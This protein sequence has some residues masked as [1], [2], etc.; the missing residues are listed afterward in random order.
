MIERG[1]I[2]ATGKI[3]AAIIV[4]LVSLASS[5]TGA[6]FKHENKPQNLK[7]LFER[8][9][10]EIYVKKD[11]KQAT[12][13]FRSLIPDEARTMKALKDNAAPD[14]LRQINDMHA[15]LGSS[16]TP[17]GIG[18]VARATQKEVQVHGATTED[19]ARYRDG[20][21]AY[22]E[23]P[24]GAKRVAEQALR[25]GVTFYEVEYLDPGK[26]A[27][28]KYHLLYWDGKQWSML[29]PVWRVMKQE[30]P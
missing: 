27:G 22:K 5:A 21:V 19:I 15:R 30:K 9:H 20:S 26:S 23:F 3:R 7:A 11:A 14:L 25:P 12:A 24:G 13:L 8:I 17:E 18:K 28:M 16:I 10:Q 6:D 4:G 1:N 29:G 2:M